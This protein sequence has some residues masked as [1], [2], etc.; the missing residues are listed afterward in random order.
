MHSRWLSLCL[1]L[2]LIGTSSGQPRFANIFSDHA[3][4]QQGTD[5]AVW[6][7]G[8]ATGLAVKIEFGE[9]TVKAK[10][11]RVGN[12]LA[13]LPARNADPRG[14]DLVL[15]V[16][17]EI[18]DRLHDI[19]VGEV[20]LAAGQSNMQFPVRQM[21]KHLPEAKSWIGSARRPTIRVRRINDPVLKDR[22]AGAEDIKDTGGW[23]RMDPETVLQFSAVAAV[24]ARELNASQNVPIGVLDVS[25]GGKPIEPFIPRGMF[26]H[27]G[28]KPILKMANEGHLDE[29]AKLSGGV[30]IRNPEG[31]PGAIF[32]ARIGPLTRYALKGAIWYQAESNCGRGEDPRR[33]HIKQRALIEGWRGQWQRMDLPCYY[34]QLPGFPDA[35]GWIRMREEQRLA[36]A[37]PNTGMAVT[38]DI[39]GEG[40]HPPDKLSVGRRLAKIALANTY[41]VGG[42]ETAG[43]IYDRH[44]I[45]ESEVTVH[46]RNVGDGLMVGDKLGVGLPREAKNGKVKW[47]ELAD[48]T[49]SWHAAFAQIEGDR[50][51]VRSDRVKRPVAV[52]YACHVQPQGKNL[53]NRAGFPASPFCSDLDLLP[54]DDHGE[55]N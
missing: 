53:Y 33:Y 22:N 10:V 54:W 9:I 3:V 49:G 14:R 1:F 47:F 11:D 4:F 21:S 17:G 15:I 32:N 7:F 44:E 50:V 37:V 24:F 25:W 52:R 55:L 27:H 41:G 51:R 2:T 18:V 28:L 45:A 38:I 19:V 39:R 13:R 16:D 30:I 34:V 23:V 26:Y 48:S 31:H 29:L 40:I 5:I 46:F 43:P 42:N 20:W 36:L 12:W 8:I 6:G 35:T